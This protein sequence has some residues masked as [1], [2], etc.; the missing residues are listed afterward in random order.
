MFRR[1]GPL[2]RL[3]AS[4]FSVAPT[5]TPKDMG[6]KV[7]EHQAAGEDMTENLT[8]EFVAHNFGLISYRIKKCGDEWEAF[9]AA[10]SAAL[11]AFTDCAFYFALLLIIYKLGF[12]YGRLSI[13]S[14]KVPKDE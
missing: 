4:A 1:Q 11:P 8:N 2:L 6:T 12:W 14:L 7:K 3:A 13:R 10:P 9:R 5:D